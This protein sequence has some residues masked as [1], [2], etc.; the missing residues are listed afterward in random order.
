[1]PDIF[2]NCRACE[3]HLVVDE[4]GAGQT[5]N[6]PDCNASIVIPIPVRPKT[7]SNSSVAK[8]AEPVPASKY[9]KC[10]YCAE[11]ILAEAKKCRYCGEMLDESLR[12][13]GSPASAPPQITHPADLYTNLRSE[14]E[15]EITNAC[16]SANVDP[17][18]KQVLNDLAANFD[19]IDGINS[20]WKHF[21]TSQKSKGW[22]SKKSPLPETI[23]NPGT[24]MGAMYLAEDVDKFQRQ[25]KDVG[26]AV[27]YFLYQLSIRDKQ[28][29]GDPN[30]PTVF[31]NNKPGMHVEDFDSSKYDAPIPLSDEWAKLSVIALS[32]VLLNY[33]QRHERAECQETEE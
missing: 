28:I 8:P 21:Y 11:E 33:I 7:A 4:A 26:T 17:T 5:I 13:A 2:F 31:P 32:C 29:S 14:L 9:K 6:C 18:M 24:Y 25:N 27:R 1:M 22:F 10:P 23:I 30:Y 3:K 19:S 15:R 12:L 20:V 16:S